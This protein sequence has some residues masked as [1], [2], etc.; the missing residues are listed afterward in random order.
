MKLL[1]V[2]DIHYN[3]P[4]RK[5]KIKKLA[6]YVNDSDA[7]YFIIAGDVGVDY[8][9][10]QE[11]LSLFQNFKGGKIAVLGNH[12]LWST[13]EDFWTK[14]ENLFDLYKK[15]GFILLD[16]KPFVEQEIAFVG[17]IGWY[18]YSFFDPS[19]LYPESYVRIFKTHEWKKV[20]ELSLEDWLDLLQR[21]TM[22]STTGYIQWNDVNF[23]KKNISDE[24]LT[25]RMVDL[26]AQHL[27]SLPTNVKYVIAVIHHIPFEE[28]IERRE[29]DNCWSFGNAFVGSKKF[30]DLIKQDKRIR[31]VICGHQHIPRQAVIE[32][33]KKE[34]ILC[35]EASF[36]ENSP[37][38]IYLNF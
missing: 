25:D 35:Y 29:Y 19:Y 27:K 24:E 36:N 31:I 20:K 32:R 23:I 33:N 13:E 16:R 30:G 5:E 34:R 1:A 3:F 22:W 7:K 4:G 11:C 2:S 14:R 18:D 8:H 38:E 6:D 10:I 28:L 37:C 15:C 21:K 26:F 12:D 9:E 17:N